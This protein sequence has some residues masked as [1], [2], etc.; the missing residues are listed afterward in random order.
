MP[1]TVTPASAQCHMVLHSAKLA[2]GAKSRSCAAHPNGLQPYRE[3]YNTRMFK[4]FCTFS[5]QYCMELLVSNNSPGMLHWWPDSA[6]G[7]H[8]WE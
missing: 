5:D 2:R 4:D 7:L 6:S 8:A 1:V 3:K